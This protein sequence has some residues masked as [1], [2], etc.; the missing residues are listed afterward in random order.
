MAFQLANELACI[1]HFWGVYEQN[2]I[3]NSVHVVGWK[4]KWA[5]IASNGNNVCLDD[6]AAERTII[7]SNEFHHLSFE[8]TKLC[9]ISFKACTEHQGNHE[10]E[11]AVPLGYFAFQKRNRSVGKQWYVIHV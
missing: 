10:R 2:S 11:T 9:W 3:V 1:N 8:R 7:A 5:T 4:V 6:W